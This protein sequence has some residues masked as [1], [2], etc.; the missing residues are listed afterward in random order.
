MFRV[1]IPIIVYYP[2]YIKSMKHLNNLVQLLQTVIFFLLEKEQT[3]TFNSSVFCSGQRIVI[4]LNL[5][6]EYKEYE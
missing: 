5:Q 6:S 1:K 4:Q 2:L 3:K